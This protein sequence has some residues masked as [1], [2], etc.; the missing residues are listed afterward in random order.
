MAKKKHSKKKRPSR[1]EKPREEP[2]KHSSL[3]TILVVVVVLAT[4]TAFLWLSLK[5]KTFRLDFGG[6]N[7]KILFVERS[8]AFYLAIFLIALAAIVLFYKIISY[9]KWKRRLK[10]IF[11]GGKAKETKRKAIKKSPV[12]TEKKTAHKI[13]RKEGKKEGSFYFSLFLFSFVLFFAA[14]F[15][16]NTPTMVLAL[17]L[18]FLSLLGYRKL[19]GY[20]MPTFIQMFKKGEAT[21]SKK[22]PRLPKIELGRYETAFDALHKI[23]EQK[24]KLKVS[25]I[26]RYF[27]VNKKKV[28]EWASILE[29]HGLL[30]LY[31]PPFGEPELRRKKS[32]GG[33][34]LGN[35][36]TG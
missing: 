13:I 4:L 36:R 27:S 8:L 19:K 24:G 7:F 32:L 33:K 5:H 6:Y 18:M 17:L 9:V 11:K 15:L 23:V 26:A 14:L 30:E 35:T 29:E 10:A 2:T 21:S 34:T 3:G 22:S 12:K 20:G 28:E 31:Y 16:R 25:V 1:K